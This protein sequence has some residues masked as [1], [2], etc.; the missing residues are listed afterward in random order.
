[1]SALKRVGIGIIGIGAI[2]W[3]VVH[4]YKKDPRADLYFCDVRKDLVEERGKE[5]GAKK[6][7]ADYHELLKDNKVDA[8]EILL[9]PNLHA[10][11][12][13]DA[14]EAGKHVSCIK[15]MARNLDECDQMISAAKRNAVKL[16]YA[17]SEYY[18]PPIVRAKELIEGG[19]IGEPLVI[20]QQI[21]GGYTIPSRTL[22]GYRVYDE[23]SMTWRRDEKRSRFRNFIDAGVHRLATAINLFNDVDKVKAWIAAEK[24]EPNIAIWKHKTKNRRG[25]LTDTLYSSSR[26]LLEGAGYGPCERIEITGTGGFLWI[27]SV[28]SGLAL[29]PKPAPLIL[30]KRDATTHFDNIEDSIESIGGFKQMA[31]SLVDCIL[32]DKEPVSKGLEGKKVLQFALA[33]CQSADENGEISVDSVP[34]QAQWW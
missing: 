32:E 12:S 7:Y 8:V 11:V 2:S 3:F 18:F 31:S 6:V 13:I 16:R 17:E 4:G 22:P 14:A 5:W 9:P 10:H 28:A 20:Y 26:V 34:Y 24:G 27:P 1:V 21:S 19:E 29:T 23:A 15:P 33:I 25:L 30:Y